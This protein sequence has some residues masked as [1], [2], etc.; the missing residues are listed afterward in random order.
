MSPATK[1][2]VALLVASVVLL[3]VVGRLAGGGGLS[4]SLK[5]DATANASQAKRLGGGGQAG[6]DNAQQAEARTLER[7]Q[8]EAAARFSGGAA[9][10]LLSPPPAIGAA[11]FAVLEGACG[12]LI[13]GKAETA[14]LPPASLTKIITAMVVSRSGVDLQQVVPVNVSG[15]QMA[16][17]GSSVM[18]IEP[19]MHVTFNDLLYGLMLPSGNDAALAVA[20]ALGDGDVQAFLDQMNQLARH[21]GLRDSH[22][23]NPHGLDAPGLYSSALDMAL[24]GRAYLQDP[25]LAPIAT[26]ATYKWSA[27][28]MRNG[29]K[30]LAA[31]PGAYGVKIGY[32]RRARQTIVVAANRDGRELIVSVFG[33]NDRYLDAT[34]LLDWAFAASPRSC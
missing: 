15:A 8:R 20:E 11:A 4:P 29:N 31:Y 6:L 21:L 32:T 27:A 16:A 23:T 30:M 22:F 28:T 2:F 7:L 5:Q 19:G 17:R 34:L 9:P 25:T 13:A 18:G 33:S 12:H 14:H 10:A 24:A 1:S 3:L 26:T